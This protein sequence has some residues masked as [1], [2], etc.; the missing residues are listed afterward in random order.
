M[1]SGL[2]LHS[3]AILATVARS[4]TTITYSKLVDLL[5][6]PCVPVAVGR[7]ILEP[8]YRKYIS[9]TTRPDL[10]AIVVR[11]DTGRPGWGWWSSLERGNL[12]NQEERTSIWSQEL[13]AVWSYPWPDHP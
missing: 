13:E 6:W 8:L 1:R 4:Q 11:A 12:L 9:G 10:L 3:W 7:H 5:D 2:L